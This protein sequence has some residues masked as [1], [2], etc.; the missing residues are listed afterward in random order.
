MSTKQHIIFD[1]DRIG[2]KDLSY[3]FSKFTLDELFFFSTDDIMTKQNRHRAINEYLFN[4]M[5]E[6]KYNDSYRY[7]NNIIDILL[8]PLSHW[9]IH[10]K[11]II[12]FSIDEMDKL[13]EWVSNITNTEFKLKHVNSS[14]FI[15]T[16]IQLDS[17][18][19]LKYDSIYEYYESP[20]SNKSII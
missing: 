18:F 19:M 8:T 14:S 13:E 12:W 3:K 4:M 6:L 9:H 2:L 7:I 15:E 17:N 1:L 11:N 10:H 16:D 5:P 20:K